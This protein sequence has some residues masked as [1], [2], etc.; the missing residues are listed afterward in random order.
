MAEEQGQAPS[1]KA[2]RWPSLGKAVHAT[3]FPLEWKTMAALRRGGFLHVSRA[4]ADEGPRPDWLAGT[5]MH[6]VEG[7]GSL[8]WSVEC[9]D[10]PEAVWLLMA[11]DQKG[12]PVVPVLE[13][14]PL[15]QQIVEQSPLRLPPFS[16]EFTQAVG[17]PAAIHGISARKSPEGWVANEH[18]LM[19]AIQ[20]A[21][22]GAFD[23]WVE[24]VIYTATVS[25]AQSKE[26]LA[27][28]PV[29][30]TTATM[31][32]VPPPVSYDDLIAAGEPEA[33]GSKVDQCVVWV[34]LPPRFRAEAVGR[35]AAWVEEVG[36][37]LFETRLNQ[38]GE[39]VDL[40]GESVRDFAE[41]MGSLAAPHAAVPVLLLNPG[42]VQAVAGVFHEAM[43]RRFP[44]PGALE[45]V[46]LWWGEVKRMVPPEF[47]PSRPPDRSQRSPGDAKGRKGH[48]EGR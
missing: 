46:P 43:R 38:R 5:T 13:T 39:T 9:K 48:R 24:F 34:D 10:E 35:I 20:Q 32:A 40:D 44:D 12:D 42:R 47:L 29:V 17:S 21:C 23:A 45:S 8:V 4:L 6:S 31:Y 33:V 30:S 14:V 28:T 27:I 41:F 3:G 25:D 15:I 1:G 26:A 11:A 37:G 16:T 18:P 36:M 22:A 19:S 2:L 7:R